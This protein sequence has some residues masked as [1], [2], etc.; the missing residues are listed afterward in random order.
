MGRLFDIRQD[1]LC[2]AS[3]KYMALIL[4]KHTILLLNQHLTEYSLHFKLDMARSA[5]K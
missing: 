4:T 1:L 3:Y 2:E 5:T